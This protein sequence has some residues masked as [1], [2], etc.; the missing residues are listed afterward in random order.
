VPRNSCD[1]TSDEVL[2]WLKVAASEEAARAFRALNSLRMPRPRKEAASTGL[3]EAMQGLGSSGYGDQN[4]LGVR[5]P[6][7]PPSFPD[8]V[9]I[10]V[11]RYLAVLDTFYV[12]QG[13]RKRL[14]GARLLR[15]IGAITNAGAVSTSV[16]PRPTELV[17][18]SPAWHFPDSG[19]SWHLREIPDTVLNSIRRGPG[20]FDVQGFAFRMANSGAA[21]LYENAQFHA[22]DLDWRGKPDWY[23]SLIGYQ[24]PNGGGRP[25]GNALGGWGTFYDLR[26]P[27]NSSHAWQS[28]DMIVEG[29]TTVA[30]FA[31]LLQTNTST[32]T[33]ITLPAALIPT[34]ISPEEAFAVNWT[35][36]TEWRAAGSLVWEDV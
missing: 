28:L 20:P 35:N 13:C 30:L 22:F 27:W 32:R 29:P 2:H 5:W 14:R 23:Q 18:S 24:P 31:S 33:A 34:G 36:A 25:W 4:W 1:P 19:F 16:P 9:S 17:V 7:A 3:D 8:E 10:G 21:L 11:G 26:A 15:S 6:A 12:P